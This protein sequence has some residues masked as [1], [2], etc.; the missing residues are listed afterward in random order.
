[1]TGSCKG[2]IPGLDVFLDFK[3]A[4]DS[5]AWNF[6]HKC[7]K[8]FNFGHDLQQW[9]NVFYMNISSCVSNNGYAS[10]H[11]H[12]VHGVRQGCPLSGILFIIAIELLVQSIRCS[13]QLKY[14]CFSPYHPPPLQNNLCYLFLGGSNFGCILVVKEFLTLMYML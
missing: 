2:P 14:G 9:I 3:K 8:T 1:M 4:F 13:T 10:K 11:F 12:L 6:I 5:I 7:L